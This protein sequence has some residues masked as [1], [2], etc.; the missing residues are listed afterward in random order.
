MI[1]MASPICRTIV[2]PIDLDVPTESVAVIFSQAEAPAILGS[3]LYHNTYGRFSIF[4]ADPMDL[5]SIG[6]GA[7]ASPIDL[8]EE[9]VGAYPIAAVTEAPVPFTGGWIGFI[10]YEAGLTIEGI[11]SAAPWDPNLPLVRFGLYDAA[12]VY[13]HGARKWYAVAVDWQERF[14][15]GRGSARERIAQVRE[16][17]AQSLAVAPT[18]DPPATNVAAPTPNMSREAYLSRVRQA[19]RYITAGD[20]YQVNLTQ[21]FTTHTSMSPIQSYRCLCRA[22][23]A[24]YA[25]LAACGDVAVLSSS[26]E[27][28]LRLCGGH[29][30]TRPIKGTRP[31]GDDVATNRA[32]R[33][34]LAASEKDRAELTMIVDLLRNDLGRVCSYGSVRVTAPGQIEEH[35]TVFHRVATVEGDLEATRDWADL[36]R[37]AFPGGSVTGAPKIRAMQIISELEPTSRG[38]YCG[39][40]GWIGLDGSMCLN[41]AIR[42]MVQAGN[43]VHVY[44]GGAI[45]ADSDPEDEYEETIAKAAGMLRALGCGRPARSTRSQEVTPL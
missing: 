25:A 33:A 13:D 24:P 31:R 30:V 38:V 40:I 9:R 45:I 7:A 29:V 10:T 6:C 37:A 8:L 28:L 15:Q 11:P 17:L 4:A 19:K 32:N 21:R 41:L 20:I 34:A 22:N 23:P 3:H 1:D 5:V 26:P 27:L 44:A 2:E 14:A 16:R 36:L 42:T 35:P 18:A 43:E 39:S 12:A